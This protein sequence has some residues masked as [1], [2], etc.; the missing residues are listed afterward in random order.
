[1]RNRAK[2]ALALA[3]C[4]AW[5]NLSAQVMAQTTTLIPQKPFIV[6]AWETG[7][8]Q[9]FA[10]I[11]VL[12]STGNDQMLGIAKGAA[13][14]LAPGALKTAASSRGE[15]TL[16]M[17]SVYA[18]DPYIR[19][20][21]IKDVAGFRTYLSKYQDDDIRIVFAPLDAKGL[22]EQLDRSDHKGI[23]LIPEFGGEKC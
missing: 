18:G 15:G 5:V 3:A 11:G 22:D 23:T 21:D 4:F 20:I 6:T 7:G 8:C 1:M 2:A 17:S 10:L 9:Q 19:A 14:Y 16:G 13:P 12:F